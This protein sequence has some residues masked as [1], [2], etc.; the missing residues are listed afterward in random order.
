M[1][2]ENYTFNTW[3]SQDL[4]MCRCQFSELKSEYTVMAVFTKDK[5]KSFQSFQ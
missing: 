3:Y 1:L 4:N 5:A 2:K